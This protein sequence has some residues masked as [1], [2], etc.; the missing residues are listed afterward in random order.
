MSLMQPLAYSDSAHYTVRSKRACGCTRCRHEHF[1][2]DDLSTFSKLSSAKYQSI[3][4]TAP[5]TAEN[6]PSNLMFGQANRYISINDDVTVLTL[7]VHANLYILNGNDTQQVELGELKKDGDGI[8]KLKFTSENT[9][10]LVDLR[11]LSIVYEKDS[12]KQT[13]LLG[14]F[15]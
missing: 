6:T 3:P 12:E 1:S 14:Q 4:L 10:E 2:K 13:V 8:Y 7:D 9:K 11:V 15:V 5:N